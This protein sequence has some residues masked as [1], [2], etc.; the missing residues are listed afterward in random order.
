MHLSHQVDIVIFQCLVAVP[1]SI[2]DGV[3][4]VVHFEVQFR[5]GLEHV[6]LC[7]E[8]PKTRDKINY[9]YLMLR[10]EKYM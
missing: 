4:C 3:I 8:D 2:A 9:F 1:H 10:R 7:S 5:L 6:Y